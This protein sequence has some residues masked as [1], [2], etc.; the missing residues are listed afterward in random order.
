MTERGKRSISA[1]RRGSRASALGECRDGRPRQDGRDPARPR[2]TRV[3]RA[4]AA[5]GRARDGED[6]ARARDRRQRRRRVVLP[7]PVHA[8]PA[9]DRRHRPVR[10]Q[11]ARPRLRVP[12]RP[13]VRERP[14]RRR[15]QPRDAEDAV[16][17][18]RGDGG[19]AGDD[20]RRHAPLP[21]PFLVLATENPIEQ[22]GTFPL[23]R[24]S[25]TASSSAPPSATR[26]RTTSCASSRSRSS[27]IRSRLLR[28]NS[29][30]TR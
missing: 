1:A 21:E 10:L 27:A 28:P 23:P 20:R 11:P 7:H 15:D 16:G 29:R 30:S 14:A 13:D 22:E 6:R 9:A 18:A 26:A 4:R 17:P 19:A 12:P 25:S 8:R 3:R 24:R 5:R 2:R